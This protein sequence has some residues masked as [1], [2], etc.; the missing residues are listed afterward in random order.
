MASPVRL[1][2]W[3]P[4][5]EPDELLSSW[6]MRLALGNAPKVQTF[7]H[8]VWP[9]VQLW[10]RD[11]DMLAPEVVLATLSEGPGVSREVVVGTTLRAFEG[12]LFECAGPSTTD[13]VLPAGIYH[14]T[15]RRAGLQWCPECLAA[16]EE[17]YYRRRWR[18]ALAS[19][20]PRH[21]VVLAERCHE[22]GRPAAPHRGWDP[23]CDV[24]YADRRDTPVVQADA[25]AL[26]FEHRMTAMLEGQPPSNELEALHPLAYFGLIR[27]VMSLV[28]S[29]ERSQ[30]LR[31]E[32]AAQWGGD[33]TPAT[34]NQLEF[35]SAVER[36]RT[37]GL[38]ARIMRGWPWLFVAH[39]AD[40]K[41][42][43][44]WAFGE[45]RYGRSPY[46]FA[47]VVDCYLSAPT[48]G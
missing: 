5:P 19:T 1:W 15:R 28:A 34:E 41:V 21:G 24:C 39:C 4:D 17:P 26:Q 2:P 37:A 14:R 35:M 7:C 31:N 10:N 36:H 25:W 16:D 12:V 20:C 47:S 8:S 27:Q 18:L 42:W 44:S 13:W 45:R 48:G 23:L 6:L 46:A 43:K 38:A 30:A 22:C 40:A 3:R 29:G 9:G 11:L 32:I 33:P